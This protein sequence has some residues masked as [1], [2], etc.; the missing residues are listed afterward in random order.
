MWSTL[1]LFVLGSVSEQ[2]SGAVAEGAVCA[3]LPES[4]WKP[5]GGNSCDAGSGGAPGSVV[6]FSHKHCHQQ[7]RIRIAPSLLWAAKGDLFS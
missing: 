7:N 2:C 1:W 3:A 4:N 6:C 5:V